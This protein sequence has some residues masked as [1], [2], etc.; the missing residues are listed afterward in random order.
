MSQT[1]AQ[2]L[3]SME[4]SVKQEVIVRSLDTQQKVAPCQAKF[5]PRQAKEH[6]QGGTR[7]AV[8]K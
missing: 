2:A 6:Q 5:A 7:R 4:S 8:E 1:T 3:V